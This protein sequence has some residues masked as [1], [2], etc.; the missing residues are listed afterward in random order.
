MLLF[1]IVLTTTARM[2]WPEITE[3]TNWLREARRR[4]QVRRSAHRECR[5][6]DEEHD[7]LLRRHNRR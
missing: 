1:V 5:N 4:W 3:A 6:L 7:H 2:F